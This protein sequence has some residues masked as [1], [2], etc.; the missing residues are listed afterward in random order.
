MGIISVENSN[1]VATNLKKDVTKTNKK[2]SHLYHQEKHLKTIPKST[3]SKETLV[4]YLYGNN[5]TSIENLNGYPNLTSLYL[6]NNNI[7]EIRNLQYLK[8]LKKLY[9]G[10]NNISV[11][12]GL[13]NLVSLEELHIEKQALPNGSC[14]CFDPR[15]IFAISPTLQILNV[16]GNNIPS[17]S[18]LAP[19]R[20]LRVIDASDNDLDDI[21]DICQSIRNWYYLTEANFTGNSV[22]K[23]HRYRET[24]IGN[25]NLL[26]LLD[27]KNVSDVTRS[28][29]KKF[30]EEKLLRTK[31]GVI[32]SDVV[33]GLPK[34][35]PPP[36]KKA[37]SA[38]ML[39][40]SKCKLVDD[41]S[42]FDEKNAVYIAWQAMP[43][44][45][46]YIKSPLLKRKQEN[47]MR[48]GIIN[49]FP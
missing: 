18:S 19:L 2:S 47:S 43:K 27:G 40:G 35:Y 41:M 39:K 30:E 46:P 48:S 38:S 5:L 20:N 21:K 7:T 31:Q 37:V 8:K 9:I 36:L 12:E 25:T 32:L 49:K 24:V 29:V 23:K 44:R 14:L 33:K 11:L 45:R 6:Q 15:T 16:S 34:N 22:G 17:L 26:R 28:F 3:L 10:H 42:T 13:N 1:S 4:I